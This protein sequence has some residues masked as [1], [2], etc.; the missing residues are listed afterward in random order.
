MESNDDNNTENTLSIN[1][2]QKLLKISSAD[3][4]YYNVCSELWETKYSSKVCIELGYATSA[5][6]KYVP[7]SEEQNLNNTFKLNA[8][9]IND[10]NNNNLLSMFE[11]SD[12]CRSGSVVSITCQEFSEY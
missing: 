6:T 3:D 5:F 7:L 12:G 2:N 1:N 9:A 4:Q 10:D 11:L 8:A